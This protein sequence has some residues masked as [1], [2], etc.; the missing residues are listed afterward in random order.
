MRRARVRLVIP[1]G[2]AVAGAV[3]VTAAGGS[4]SW[5]WYAGAATPSR[6]G[7]G[8]TRP[9]GRTVGSAEAELAARPARSPTPEDWMLR[10]Q[11]AMAGTDRR[12][13]GGSGREV[14]DAHPLAPQAKLR[15]GQLELAGPAPRRRGGAAGRPCT[16]PG[17]GAARRELI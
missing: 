7:V 11:V 16:R 4:R 12:G 1:A 15:A 10:A 9:S 8:R 14:P 5:R 3:A 2:L 13:A 17:A 6:S